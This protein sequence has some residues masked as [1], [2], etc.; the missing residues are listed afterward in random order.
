[1]IWN[2]KWSLDFYYCLFDDKNM[3]KVRDYRTVYLYEIINADGISS[4]Q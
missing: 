4:L 2:I 3:I 1:M